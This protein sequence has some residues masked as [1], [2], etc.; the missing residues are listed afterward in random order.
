MKKKGILIFLVLIISVLLLLQNFSFYKK[1]E[2]VLSDFKNQE[3]PENMRVIPLYL[4]RDFIR[5]DLCEM[6]KGTNSLAEREYFLFLLGVLK[7]KKSHQTIESCLEFFK[8][9]T[10]TKIL[11]LKALIAIDGKEKVKINYKKYKQDIFF[12]QGYVDSKGN[13]TH[14]MPPVDI[15][16]IIDKQMGNETTY[17]ISYFD[18]YIWWFDFKP[19]KII[20]TP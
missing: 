4:G 15:F 7:D 6:I 10:Y 17:N 13:F 19:K 12:D 16:D 20:M 1:K 2:D 18:I 14:E 11:C 5:N 9:D 3:A 8:E